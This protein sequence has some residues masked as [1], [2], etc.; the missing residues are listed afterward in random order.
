MQIVEAGKIFKVYARKNQLKAHPARMIVNGQ[1][2]EC[3]KHTL[4]KLLEAARAIKP[5]QS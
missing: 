4:D 3:P 5:A 1:K 2:E